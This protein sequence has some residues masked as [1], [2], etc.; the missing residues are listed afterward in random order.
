M[1]PRI[2]ASEAAAVEAPEAAAIKAAKSAIAT[3]AATVK[4]TSPARVEIA[5]AISAGVSG[6]LIPIQVTTVESA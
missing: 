5:P 1:V 2:L 4:T 6:H 3:P